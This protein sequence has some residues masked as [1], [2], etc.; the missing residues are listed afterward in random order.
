L[1][2]ACE[3][4]RAR[5]TALFA[6]DQ[7]VIDDLQALKARVALMLSDFSAERAGV[8]QQLNAAGVRVVAVPLLPLADGYYFTADNAVKAAQ[9]FEEWTHWTKQH[10]LVWDGVGLDIEPDARIFQQ[11]MDNPWGLIPMLAPRLLDRRRARQ[12]RAE[13]AALV[14]RIRSEGWKVENYQFP[15]IA[16]ERRVGSTLLQRLALVDV[17]TDREVWMLHSSFMRRLGPGLIWSYGPHAAAIGVGS[18]GGGPDIP[19]SPQVPELSWDELARDLKLARRWCDDILIHSLEGCVWHGFLARLRSFD[20]EE[21]V[22]P[23]K[24]AWLARG[25]RAALA[26]ALWT[27]AHPVP[28][29]GAASASAWVLT[30]RRR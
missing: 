12:P 23:P 20:W 19:G 6:T 3:L 8:V 27:S 26:A 16:D 5:L 13:Y 29:L 24:Q 9:R 14:D 21:P 28:V 7:N 4:D 11:I 17:A 15:L 30:R 10:R 25:F 18:T 2:F 1:T 22:K